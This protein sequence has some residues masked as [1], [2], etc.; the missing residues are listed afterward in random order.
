[1]KLTSDELKQAREWLKDCQ[2]RDLEAGDV[3]DMPDETVERG[4]AKHYDGGL[5]EFRK[6]CSHRA[7]PVAAHTPAIEIYTHALGASVIERTGHYSKV[8]QDFRSLEEANAFVLGYRMA[9]QTR[10]CNSHAALVEALALLVSFD[11][12]Q[13]MADHIRERSG[14][15]EDAQTPE[16]TIYLHGMSAARAALALAKEAP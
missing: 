8:I 12:K 15:N 4:V 10:A 11:D 1:M 9:G 5:A 13:G 3:D 2:W 14:N 7:Q 6:N 16:E